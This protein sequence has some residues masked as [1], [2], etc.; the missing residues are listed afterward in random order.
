MIRSNF[1]CL[2]SVFQRFVNIYPIL[3]PILH[4]I[5]SC[6][7]GLNRIIWI[8][9]TKPLNLCFC[10]PAGGLLLNPLLRAS[11][12]VGVP[13]GK[14]DAGRMGA[15]S[16]RDV[17]Q[18]GAIPLGGA[19]VLGGGGLW[20]G[21]C[22]WGTVSPRGGG[23]PWGRGSTRGGG[24]LR[25]GRRA[26]GACGAFVLPCSSWPPE[27]RD[28]DLVVIPPDASALGPVFL[29]L[30]PWPGDL[31]DIYNREKHYVKI[32]SVQREN[33]LLCRL[34]IHL[35]TFMQIVVKPFLFAKYSMIGTTFLIFG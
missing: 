33:V 31:P 7:L 30:W 26:S 28:L 29:P 27:S 4:W 13:W 18:E 2:G 16:R 22:M 11:P 35:F 8:S 19:A 34:H 23:G 17:L 12:E 10:L 6:K 25:G 15:D 5:V 3:H 9:T 14:L 32:E 1:E 21:C 20:C 24:C